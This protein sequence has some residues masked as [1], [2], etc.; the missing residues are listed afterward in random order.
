MFKFPDTVKKP[1]QSSE[2]AK[3]EPLSMATVDHALPLDPVAA[4][5]PSSSAEQLKETDKTWEPPVDQVVHPT[6]WR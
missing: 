5:A 3:P 2:Q 1:A 4:A 6:A